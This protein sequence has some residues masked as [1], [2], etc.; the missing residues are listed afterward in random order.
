M[1]NEFD[2]FEAIAKSHNDAHPDGPHVTSTEVRQELRVLL[3]MYG[4]FKGVQDDSSEIPQIRHCSF[5]GRSSTQVEGLIVGP[6]GFC[7][8]KECVYLCQEYFRRSN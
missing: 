1:I 4:K 5:C 7:I 6:G 8:C 2:I 3:S